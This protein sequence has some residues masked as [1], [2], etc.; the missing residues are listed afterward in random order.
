VT[1]GQL[2]STNRLFFTDEPFAS[3]GKHQEMMDRGSL[4]APSWRAPYINDM[5]EHKVT[6]KWAREG[7]EFSYQKYSRDH[8]WSFDGGQTAAG[9]LVDYRVADRVDFIRRNRSNPGG[10]SGRSFRPSRA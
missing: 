9:S 1:D 10:R 3:G 4:V 2:L 6:L 7:A 8:T 5:S